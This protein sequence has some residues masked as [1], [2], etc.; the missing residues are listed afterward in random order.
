MDQNS[1]EAPGLHAT[2]F[3]SSSEGKIVVALNDVEVFYGTGSGVRFG[4]ILTARGGC[5]GGTLLI[6]T[7]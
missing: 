4:S 6:L 3:L 1:G 7:A 2:S 5:G